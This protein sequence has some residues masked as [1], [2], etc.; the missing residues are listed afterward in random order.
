MSYTVIIIMLT[1]SFPANVQSICTGII[2]SIGQLG[3][4][5]GPF[6]ITACINLKVYPIIVL[7]VVLLVMVV[8]PVSFMKEPKHTRTTIDPNEVQD[9]GESIHVSPEEE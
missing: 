7:S 6:L 8:L 1:E 2:E 3:S 4:F 5:I 9:L